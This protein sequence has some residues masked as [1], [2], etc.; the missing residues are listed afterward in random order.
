[1]HLIDAS[2]G[3]SAGTIKFLLL[4]ILMHTFAKYN[5]LFRDVGARPLSTST[6][7][8]IS[9][10]DSSTFVCIQICAENIP[11]HLFYGILF[12]RLENNVDMLKEKYSS[13][14]NTGI[15]S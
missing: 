11:S 1:M 15:T 7:R 9:T 12:A 4:Y 2:G 8:V 14:S 10:I 13:L 5:N 3:T 6:N